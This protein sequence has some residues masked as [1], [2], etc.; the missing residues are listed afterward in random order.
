MFREFTVILFL[1]QSIITALVNKKLFPSS[2]PVPTTAQI[3]RAVD[4][5]QNAEIEFGLAKSKGKK[6]L[7]WSAQ[8]TDQASSLIEDCPAILSVLSHNAE[9]KLRK[10]FHSTL[11]FRESCLFCFCVLYFYYYYHFQIGPNAI[12]SLNE[13][14]LNS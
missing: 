3:T 12:D 6:T 9:L 5:V 13:F 8:L 7:Y 1:L 14:I 10:S 11:L 4:T 2:V